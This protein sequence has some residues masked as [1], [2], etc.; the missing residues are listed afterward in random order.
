ME[1]DL[2]ALLLA[3]ASDLVKYQS[4]VIILEASASHRPSDILG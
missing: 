3:T 2:T 1:K 4:H